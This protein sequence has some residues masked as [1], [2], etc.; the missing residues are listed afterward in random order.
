[1]VIGDWR[2]HMPNRTLDITLP[3]LPP[4]VC[5]P[6]HSSGHHWG[7]AYQA[8]IQLHANIEI[9]IAEHGWEGPPMN[10]ALITLTFRCPSGRFDLDN[11]LSAM[12]AAIDGLKPRVIV[13]DNATRV[14]YNIRWERSKVEEVHI[15]VQEEDN[16]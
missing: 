16:D 4:D 5:W 2:Q 10:K 8:R 9:L 3:Y 11:A 15:I 13:D 12:K 1:M 6:N 7:L 14:A